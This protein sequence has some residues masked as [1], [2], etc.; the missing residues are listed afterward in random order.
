MNID[1]TAGSD[2]ARLALGAS[3][4]GVD[5]QFDG[6]VNAQV[7][8]MMLVHAKESRDLN[9]TAREAEE[10]H[11]KEQ[12]DAQVQAMHDQADAVRTA[13][14]AD[15]LGAVFQGG[16]T[17]MGGAITMNG[18]T[19]SGGGLAPCDQGTV[20]YLNGFGQLGGAAGKFV[21]D[22]E[23]AHEKD[24]EADGVDDGNHADQAKRRLD[25]LKEQRQDARELTK[26]AVD[27]LRQA[28]QTKGEA[29]RA[30]VSIR[31]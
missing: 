26:T 28:E 3:A 13:G 20:T 17:M 18:A 4:D 31:A 23:R 30:A 24:L 6:D 27:F 22:M 11:L 29:D 9:D 10:K 1:K 7:A 8:A 15:C 14:F 16:L 12:Q 5:G 25:D 2:S 21:G 19:A